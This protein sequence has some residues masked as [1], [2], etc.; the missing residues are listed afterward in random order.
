MPTVNYNDPNDHVIQWIE[1]SCRE[2]VQ[3]KRLVERTM[4]A[5]E[6]YP[7]RNSYKMNVSRYANS[8]ENE[9]EKKNWQ[10]RCK[11]IPE[12]RSDVMRKSIETVVSQ[13]QGGIGQYEYTVYDPIMEVDDDLIARLESACDKFYIDSNLNGMKD[14]IARDMITNGAAYLYVK[15]DK[16]NKQ[17]KTTLI[18]SWRMLNDP[19]RLRT[20]R[21]RYTGFTQMESWKNVKSMITFKNGAVVTENDMDVYVDNIGKLINNPDFSNQYVDEN[22]LKQDIGLCYS[23]PY[24]QSR[25][26]DTKLKENNAYLGDDVEVSYVWD[27][28]NHIQYKVINRRYIVEKKEV[29]LKRKISIEQR[30]PR[31]P[32]NKKKISKPKTV[33][34]DA[35]IIEIPYLKHPKYSFPV[36]PL[37]FLLNDF[38][39]I[40]SAESLRAHNMSI[41]GP[42]NFYGSSYDIEIL[43]NA[44]NVAGIG[45]EGM[46]GTVGVLNKQHDTSII[47]EYIRIREEKIK[48]GINAVDQFDMQE[49]IGDRASAKEVGAISNTVAQ[50]LNPLVA[51]MESGIAQ[52]IRTFLKLYVIY[53]EDGAFSIN[54]NGEYADVTLEEMALDAIVKVKLQSQI[55]FKMQAVSATAMG[56][57][58]SLMAAASNGLINMDLVLEDYIPLITQGIVSRKRARQ[59]AATPAPTAEEAMVASAAG[60]MVAGSLNAEQQAAIN[61]PAQTELAAE[62][63]AMSNDELAM[64]EQTLANPNV[65]QDLAPMTPVDGLPAD[66]AGEI[67]NDIGVTI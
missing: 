30:D 2:R 48:R 64:L 65:L 40:C 27:L 49:M 58:N 35:P 25:V 1:E 8:L 5:Y 26:I 37:W 20:N 29:D 3:L 9:T 36:T 6:G 60:S 47:D 50:G 23:D 22:K 16:E 61:N 17:Y 45:I 38:D 11:S 66:I 18:E 32:E 43:S 15:Y 21:P 55:E 62:A 56:N 33:Q 63:E 67:A 53:N 59:Y 14:D 52:A 54:N 34:I 24:Y 28:A 12:G 39:E 42:L 57:L 13:L 19:N 51:S 7:L 10:L 46:D 31:D 41:M 44:A 4:R